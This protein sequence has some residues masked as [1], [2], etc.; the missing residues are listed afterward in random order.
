MM[1]VPTMP[2]YLMSQLREAFYYNDTDEVIRLNFVWKTYLKLQHNI[3]M[4]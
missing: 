4:K 3:E 2:E 1:N